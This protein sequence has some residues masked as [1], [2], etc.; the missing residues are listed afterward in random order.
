VIGTDA[1]GRP[2][3]FGAIYDPQTT[4]KALDGSNYS[5]P[6]P[7]NIIPKER[8][9]PVAANILGIGLVDPVFDKMV[10]NIERTSSCCPFFKSP[11]FRHQGRSQ[12]LRQAPRV[13]L[14]QPKLPV[15]AKQLRWRWWSLFAHP[16]PVTTSWK[17]QYTPA[18]W[19]DCRSI[20]H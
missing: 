2:I 13:R 18:K 3:V 8:F 4:R 19:A 20:P 5:G 1:L 12:R 6:I 11:H 7:G 10:R 9:D 14:L 17:D 15:E 16:R